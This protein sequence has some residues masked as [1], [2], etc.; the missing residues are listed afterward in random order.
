[1]RCKDNAL[2]EINHSFRQKAYVDWKYQL[3]KNIVTT[4]PKKRFG[5]NG[6][7]AYRF[8]TRSLPK[9]T[10]IYKQFYQEGRKIIPA[11]LKITNLSLAV[12][13]MDD[14]CKSYRAMYLNTQKFDRSEQHRLA[15]LLDT[16]H[17]I[18]TSINKDK[19][20]WRLR[21]AVGSVGMLK[22]LVKP[23]FLPSLT[24]KLPS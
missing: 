12:W 1:M 10:T 2:L 6:R 22:R 15:E 5:K 21:V 17:G 16:Q 3:F 13:V 7:I 18:K 23:H 4:P 20:Y 9:L 8:T 24:Y 11:D 14:G 19:K